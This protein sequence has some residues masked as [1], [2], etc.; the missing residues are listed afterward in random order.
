MLVGASLVVLGGLI[1]LIGVLSG[2]HK[3]AAV[4]GLII[5]LILLSCGVSVYQVRE[6]DKENRAAKEELAGLVDEVGNLSDSLEDFL[7]SEGNTPRAKEGRLALASSARKVLISV[8]RLKL[9][10]SAQIKALKKK[11][12]EGKLKPHEVIRPLRMTPLRRER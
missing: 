2:S 5:L 9:L 8:E 10:P 12:A 11:G 4:K 3:N 7:A 1:A 6:Q